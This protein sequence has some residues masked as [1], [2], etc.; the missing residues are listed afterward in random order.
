MDYEILTIASL[1]ILAVLCSINKYKGNLKHNFQFHD[2][3]MRVKAD[4]HSQGCHTALYQKSIINMRIKLYKLP[5][6][7]S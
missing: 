5:D 7:T 3:N 1:C 4:R 6:T 2:Y